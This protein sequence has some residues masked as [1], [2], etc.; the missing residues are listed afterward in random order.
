VVASRYGASIDYMSDETGFLVDVTYRP[1]AGMHPSS[2]YVGT[3]TW[4]QPDLAHAVDRFRQIHA[5]EETARV[6]G[7]RAAARIARDFSPQRIAD[8]ILGRLYRSP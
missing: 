3:Q 4:A 6:V 2:L 1:V 7:E 5:D 8:R